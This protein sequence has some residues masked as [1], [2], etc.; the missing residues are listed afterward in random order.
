[1][2]VFGFADVNINAMDLQ[3]ICKLFGLFFPSIP[4]PNIIRREKNRSILLPH[5]KTPLPIEEMNNEYGF[6][7]LDLARPDRTC[8]VEYSNSKNNQTHAVI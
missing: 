6:E 4:G 7:F 5:E 3:T 8:Q 2:C 1:M